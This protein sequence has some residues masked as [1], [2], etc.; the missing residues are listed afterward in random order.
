MVVLVWEQRP[1]SRPLSYTQGRRQPCVISHPL[2]YAHNPILWTRPLGYARNSQRPLSH[3]LWTH[4]LC[5]GNTLCYGYHSFAE[6]SLFSPKTEITSAPVLNQRRHLP[7]PTMAV[8]ASY[9]GT[10]PT[11]PTGLSGQRPLL[12]P[13]QTSQPLIRP[14]RPTSPPQAWSW[15]PQP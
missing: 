14:L 10:E 12:A 5:Y 11:F 6:I 4:P 8:A 3:I 7:S 2:G 1:W 9:F 15:F 13:S